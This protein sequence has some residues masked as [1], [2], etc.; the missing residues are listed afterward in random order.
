MNPDMK[1]VAAAIAIAAAIAAAALS[2]SVYA[3]K[4]SC[5]DLKAEIQGKLE[6]KGVKNYVLEIVAAGDAKDSAGK[7]VGS[8]DGGAKRIV[9]RRAG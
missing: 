4:R 5:E 7:V 9:Y 8:C 3:Q 2:T 6:A 1:R